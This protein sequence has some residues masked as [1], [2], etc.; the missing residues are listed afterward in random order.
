MGAQ[1]SPKAI[2]ENASGLVQDHAYSVMDVVHLDENGTKLVKIRNTWGHGEWEGEWS[3]SSPLWTP[4]IR[5][6]M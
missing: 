4:R 2:H 5:C 6:V 1:T 3:D